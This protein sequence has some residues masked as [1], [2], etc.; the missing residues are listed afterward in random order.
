MIYDNHISYNSNDNNATINKS[1]TFSILPIPILDPR[2]QRKLSPGKLANLT[3]GEFKRSRSISNG[4]DNGVKATKQI[5]ADL[6]I[7]GSPRY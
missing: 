2:E 5:R 3:T 7:T 4:S 1:N 6:N